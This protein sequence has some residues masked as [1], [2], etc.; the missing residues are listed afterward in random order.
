MLRSLSL[1]ALFT[2]AAPA[3]ACPMADAAKYRAA[4]QAVDQGPGTKV[5]L[6]VDG[7][8]SGDCS[9]KVATLLKGVDGVVDA[10]VDYQTGSTRVAFDAQ[11]TSV[12]KLISRLGEAGYKARVD[13]QS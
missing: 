7:L 4:V 11:K 9:S 6:A 5:S 3:L 13:T 2:L 8:K 10:A 1:V 12:D